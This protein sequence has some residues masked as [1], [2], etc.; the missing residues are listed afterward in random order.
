MVLT[1]GSRFGPYEILSPLGA[2]G[3]GEVYRARDAKLGREVALK[4]LPE[5]L[6]TSADRVARFQREAQVLASL[7]HPNIATIHGLEESDG[8]CALVMELVQGPTLA[9]KIGAA[10]GRPS[11]DGVFRLEERQPLE[12][13]V[14]LRIDESLRIAKQIAEGLEYAHERGVI[15][16]DLKPANVKVSPDGTVKILDFGLAK[17][18][19]ESPATASINT[20]PTISSAAT[21]EGII[22]GTA[23]YMSPEQARGKT[24]DRRSDI[25]SFGAVLFELLS[26]NQ[27]FAGEDVSHTLAAVIM[28]EPNWSSLSGHLPA[29]LERL[30]RR[31]LTKDPKQRL[32]AVGEAR[33]VIEKLIAHPE[34][35]QNV[36]AGPAVAAAPRPPWPRALPWGIAAVLVLALL[37]MSLWTG[38]R[39]T[40]RPALPLRL[41]V[42]LGVDALLDSSLAPAAALSPDGKVLAFAARPS[43]PGSTH[44]ERAPNDMSGVLFTGRQGT[45]G[46]QL[47]VRWLDHTEATPLAGTENAFG[48]FFSPDGQWIAFFADRK[49]K[50]VSVM[51][52]AVLTLC[53]A[54]NGRGGDWGED[55][56]IVF[57]P[58]IS[59]G[60]FRVSDAGGTPIELTRLDSSTGERSHR[61]PQVLPGGKAVLFT[62][63][64]SLN[65]NEANI[66]VESLGI[67]R[68]KIVERGGTLGRYL[69]GGYLIYL[70]NGTLFAAPFDLGR[71]EA[72]G[73]PAPVIEGVRGESVHG[74]AQFAFSSSDTLVYLPG[75]SSEPDSAIFWLAPDGKTAPLRNVP[76]Q[77]G[78]LRFSPDGRRLALVLADANLEAVDVWVYEYQRD[79]TSRLT[80]G[81]GVNTRPVWTPDG[82]RL[83]FASDRAKRNVGNIYWQRADGSGEVQRLTEGDNL[84][85]PS[86]WHPSGKFLAYME[87]NPKTAFDI[88]ILPME[89]SEAGGW[90]PGKPFAFLN[91][92]SNEGLAQ[93]SPDGRWIA[94][95]SDESGRFEV[96]VRPF[97]GPGG[98]W[99]ISTNGGLWPIWSPK[100]GELFYEEASDSKIMVAAYTASG[101]AFQPGKRR[102]WASNSVP[103]AQSGGAPFDV[104]P[105]GKRLAV[106]LKAPGQT[107]TGPKEDHLTFL[108][109]FTDELRRIAPKGKK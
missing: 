96:Y 21:R 92:P 49:L 106:L 3:M 95:V 32:Q 88:M 29:E 70:H 8:R 11:G 53:D 72:T 10:H 14:A 38:L 26:G 6:A 75:R 62:D 76:G 63:S 18:L 43:K 51:G 20:S 19:E 108:F 40:P 42:D 102:P 82:L 56:N 77:Y 4:V 12:G 9:E 80:F 73:A 41:S 7:N 69:P 16:R 55:G 44:G 23:A 58:R 48:P 46:T 91:D 25:W 103:F 65:F 74:S 105:D 13:G 39:P 27:A 66:V 60:L 71:L 67:G 64:T 24:V 45:G 31:C 107:E 98:K 15:H 28:S 22:L 101:S 104:S 83:A 84:Q 59:S 89:G 94:Y 78:E 57:A 109:N 5:A 97:P 36:T 100:G 34:S 90:K 81:A 37:G 86:S 1:A 47:F 17:A 33:I 93:F 54:P 52:G 85:R 79:T 68:R 99:Q 30:L 35:A 87:I 50:K 61:W 2:G